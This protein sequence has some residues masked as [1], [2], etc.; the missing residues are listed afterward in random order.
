[1]LQAVHD[2]LDKL[3]SG[4]TIHHVDKPTQLLSGLVTVW[5]GD[6]SYRLCVD[7]ARLNKVILC[8]RPLLPTVEQVLA[9][10][11]NATI[12]SK[13]DGTAS[14]HQGKISADSQKLTTFITTFSQYCFCRLCFGTAFTA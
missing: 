4:D 14:S 3:G 2:E 12:F 1:M 9:F 7:L 10:L 13:L 8:E 5:K 6:G 11:C